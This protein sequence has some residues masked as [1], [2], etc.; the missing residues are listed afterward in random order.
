M[1]YTSVLVMGSC[2]L[3]QLPELL[4]KANGYKNIKQDS[5]KNIRRFNIQ[6]VAQQPGINNAPLIRYHSPRPLIALTIYFGSYIYIYYLTTQ[7]HIRHQG[8]ITC[9]CHKVISS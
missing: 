4:L 9:N 5:K 2:Y 8:K 1:Y 3:S 6:L 7:L